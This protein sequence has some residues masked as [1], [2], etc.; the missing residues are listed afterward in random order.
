MGRTSGA[1]YGE[2]RQAPM[3]TCS[4]GHTRRVPRM[5]CT[6]G[7]AVPRA[8]LWGLWTRGQKSCYHDTV[9]VGCYVKSH[10][11]PACSDSEFRTSLRL[12]AHTI[13]D[14]L[15][16]VVDS[17]M[18]IHAQDFVIVSS[19]SHRII[20]KNR[21]NCVCRCVTRRP[22]KPHTKA[23]VTHPWAGFVGDFRLLIVHHVECCSRC[24]TPC[25]PCV[26]ACPSHGCNAASW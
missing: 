25:R 15:C 18:G 8:F 10:S 20:T 2:D 3:A 22:R 23:P 13:L 26:R 19:D 17:R 9:K 14:Q 6:Q 21:Q 12:R 24:V 1:K 16:N 4:S 5:V 7:G 11:A